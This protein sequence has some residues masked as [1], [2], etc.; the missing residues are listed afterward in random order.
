MSS[1]A[2]RTTRA[3][4]IGVVAV[5]M[6]TVGAA[7]VIAP[8]SAIVAA[9]AAGTAPVSVSASTLA[10]AVTATGATA[11]TATTTTPA[12]RSTTASRSTTRTAIAPYKVGTKKYSKW[13][14]RTY[15]A[16]RY[17]WTSQRQWQ[18]LVT[19]WNK[20]S[21]WRH[22]AHNNGSG[23]HGIPQAV[24]GK[25]MASAGPNWRTNPRTQ[26]KWGLKYI[27]G[28]YGTPCGAWSFWQNHRWY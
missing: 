27:K 24:P 7:A 22:K 11:V 8:T 26:I 28:R 16:K 9:N 6:V 5:T 10:G 15:M 12:P 2:A 14:A 19:M 17:K 21:G 1:T 23:A 4:R 20:E 25:K 13:F 3:R 18:C